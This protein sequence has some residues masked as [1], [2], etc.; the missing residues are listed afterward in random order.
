[1]ELLKVTKDRP[2]R[3]ISLRERQRAKITLATDASPEGIG[4]VLIVNNQVVSA[5][6]SPVTE[7]DAKELGFEL[8][9]SS[10]QGLVEGLAFVAALDLWGPKM[11]NLDLELTIQSDSVTAL[12][13]AQK[14]SAASAGLNFL[15]AVLGIMLER[16]KVEEVKLLHIPGAAN[17]TADYLSRPSI[18]KDKE[19]P[20]A[21]RSVKVE[22]GRVRNAEFYP[23]PTPGRAPDLWLASVSEDG[24]SAWNGWR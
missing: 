12:A 22:A 3:K 6:S 18:W 13:M 16:F 17:T 20:E 1:M 11:S 21:L 23:L 14:Q 2:T 10:S 24:Q 19:K 15:G 4:A 7:I 9:A 8:G 5:L